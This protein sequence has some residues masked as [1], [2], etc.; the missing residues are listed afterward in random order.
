MSVGG[1]DAAGDSGMESGGGVQMVFRLFEVSCLQALVA[2][3][4][5][6]HQ[7]PHPGLSQQPRGARAPRCINTSRSMFEPS[8]VR[9]CAA[10]ILRISRSEAVLCTCSRS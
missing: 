5:S 8:L 3:L 7:H 6:A 9:L 4:A 2:L 1:K 10:R